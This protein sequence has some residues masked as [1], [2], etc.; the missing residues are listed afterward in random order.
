VRACVRAGRHR[1]GE[2]LRHVQELPHRR[3]QGDDRDRDDERPGLAHVV[4]PDHGALLALRRE[5]QRRVQDGHVER[6]HVA[7]GDGHAAVPDAAVP[8]HAAGG[9]VG[10][11]RLRDAGPGRLRGRAAPVAR[12]QGRLLR[13]R[14]RVPGR[15]L[16]Q[17]RG[18]PGRRRRRLPAPRPAVRRPAQDHGA[19]QHPRHHG[20]PEDGPVRR[21]ADGARRARA[22]RRRARLL[23]QRQLPAREVT[24]CVG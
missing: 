5:L 22:A 10:D 4:L 13:L 17:R 19:R 16:R 15:R 6:G 21:R 8:L 9:A 14:R 20:V 12:R 2:E 11:H 18:R 3:Q 1:R 7:G 23:R 24:C